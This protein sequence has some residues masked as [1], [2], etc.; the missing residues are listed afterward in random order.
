MNIVDELKKL[1]VEIT[2]EIEKKFNGDFVALQE[3][4]RKVG[5]VEKERDNWKTAAQTAEET[6][7]GFDGK[8]YDDII[9]E[10]DT[11]KKTAEDFQKKAQEDKDRQE[12]AG[13][14]E[15]AYKT[16]KYKFKNENGY[17][18]RKIRE[19]I[20]TAAVVRN[21]KLVGFND[22]LEDAYKNDP[23]A[24]L[25]ESQG[26]A[27]EGKIVISAPIGGQD[28]KMTKEDILKI[29]DTATRQKAIAENINLFA[30]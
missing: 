9:K 4:E 20:E 1:N 7:K 10:R 25:T 18:A 6:L 13:L 27:Q 23:E 28:H 30:K 8:N 12:R 5:A 2:P 3:M 24:F 29:K 22:L 15:D 21:G 16:A 26:T 14:I 11:W 17:A 19:E